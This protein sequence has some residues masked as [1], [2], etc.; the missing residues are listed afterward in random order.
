MAVILSE[1][2]PLEPALSAAE[3]R[4]R[5]EEPAPSEAEGTPTSMR[6]LRLLF[7]LPQSAIDNRQCAY[8]PPTRNLIPARKFAR[9][10]G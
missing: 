7:V 8:S 4:V 3:G 2:A 5:V 6:R 9:S 10:A 1:D